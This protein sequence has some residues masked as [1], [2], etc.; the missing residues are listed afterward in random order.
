MDQERMRERLGEELERIMKLRSS[1][2]LSRVEAATERDS[3]AELSAMDQHPADS[4]TETFERTKDVSLLLQ[5]DAELNDI[6]HAARKLE[7]GTYGT[8]EACGDPIPGDRLEALPATRYCVADQAR[9]ERETR[10]AT[11]DQ[12]GFF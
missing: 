9:V 3:A 2:E 11:G 1:P 7:D 8:C 10:A 4:G 12:H 6:E 5:L